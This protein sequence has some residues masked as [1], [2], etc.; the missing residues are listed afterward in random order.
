MNSIKLVKNFT[1]AV[2]LSV[3][4]TTAFAEIKKPSRDYKGVTI[5]ASEA[6]R[7]AYKFANPKYKPRCK[8]VLRDGNRYVWV[9]AK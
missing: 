5:L 4:T 1:I 8:K 6:E 9:C 2:V 7:A 3:A